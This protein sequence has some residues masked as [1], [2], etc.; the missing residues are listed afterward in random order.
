MTAGN[1]TVDVEGGCPKCGNPAVMVPG[2]LWARNNSDVSE[3][4]VSR[5]VAASLRL[6]SSRRKIG[7]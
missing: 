7:R 2:R 1:V 6:A 3:M 4:R 5:Y